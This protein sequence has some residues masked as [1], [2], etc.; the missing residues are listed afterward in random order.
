V[1]PAARSVTAPSKN[2]RVAALQ[3]HNALAGRRGIDQELVNRVL[4]DA[5]LADPATHGNARC[6]PADAIEHFE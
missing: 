6:I 1:I 3:T 5:G 2:E 4:T